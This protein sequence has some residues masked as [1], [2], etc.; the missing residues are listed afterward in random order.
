MIELLLF[1]VSFL[2]VGFILGTNHVRKNIPTSEDGRELARLLR[3]AAEDRR[4]TASE[5]KALSA[6]ATKILEP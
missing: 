1:S 3:I 4:I 6:Q 5:L 2:L